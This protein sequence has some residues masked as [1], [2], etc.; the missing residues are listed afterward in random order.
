MKYSLT[1]YIGLDILIV[2]LFGF[3]PDL[4]VFL[5]KENGKGHKM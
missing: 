2:L 1:K 5:P 4:L 3:V